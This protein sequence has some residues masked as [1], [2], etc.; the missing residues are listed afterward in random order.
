MASNSTIFH[1]KIRGQPYGLYKW[2]RSPSADIK[3][4]TGYVLRAG[5]LGHLQLQIY[6]GHRVGKPH[7]HRRNKHGLKLSAW[8]IRGRRRKRSIELNIHL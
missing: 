4:N 1:T 6:N 7:E 3:G 5:P 8:G 2:T